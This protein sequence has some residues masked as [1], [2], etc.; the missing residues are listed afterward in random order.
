MRCERCKETCDAWRIQDVCERCAD[1]A[2]P[3]PAV[4]APKKPTTP[5][6][7]GR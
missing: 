7:A 1:G 4:E 6:K 3:A 2:P 5:K